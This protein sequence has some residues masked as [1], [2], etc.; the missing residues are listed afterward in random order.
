VL[1]LDTAWY[2][3]LTQEAK[4]IKWQNDWQAPWARYMESKEQVLTE[5]PELFS[6]ALREWLE[7]L[8]EK[9]AAIDV[10]EH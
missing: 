8:R 5:D 1:Y 9:W 10:R 3:I 7:K 4:M 6:P 2:N